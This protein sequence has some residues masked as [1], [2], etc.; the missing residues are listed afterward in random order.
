MRFV[1]VTNDVAFRKIFGNQKKP[2]SLIS[3]LNAVLNLTGDQQVI[4]VEIINPYLFPRIAGEK[5]SIIDVKA[6]DQAG[7]HFVVEMQVPNVRGFAKRVQYYAYRDYSMQINRGDEYNLLKPTHFIGILDFPFSSGNEYLSHHLVL[8]KSTG[9]HLL[10][11]VQFVFIEL[12]KF[13]KTEDQLET[14]VDEWTY[15]IKNSEHLVMMPENISDE[16]L[17]LAYQEADR[18]SWSKEEFLAYDDHYIAAEDAKGVVDKAV[19][20][21]QIMN[22]RS[23]LEICRLTIGEIA[24]IFNVSELFVR[25]VIHEMEAA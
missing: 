3:F 10:T 16:G 1:D 17:K 15:F 14:E 24:R 23:M 8:D 6:T 21:N 19:M 22:I 13:D 12:C 18:H 7:R 20:E 4:S 25:Q 2:A 5:A 9:E 11:D